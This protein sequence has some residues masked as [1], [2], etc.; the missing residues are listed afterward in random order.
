MFPWP[1]VV[2]MAHSSIVS[3]LVTCGPGRKTPMLFRGPVAAGCIVN[4]RKSHTISIRQ[5]DFGVA[6]LRP[7]RLHVTVL[8]MA[9]A[10]V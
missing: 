4:G 10:G 7:Q 3:W 1:H 8:A 5:E 6:R 2:C 9:L